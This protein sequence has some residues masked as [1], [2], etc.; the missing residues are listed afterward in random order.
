MTM[1]DDKDALAA[2]YVLGTL[3]PDERA[4]AHLLLELDAKFVTLVRNWERRLGELSA[5]VA[6][7]E[8]PDVTWAR[9]KARV[10]GV[11]PGPLLVLPTVPEPPPKP[12]PRVAPPVAPPSAATVPPLVASPPV[13]SASPADSAKVVPLR[14]RSNG[15]RTAALLSG[16]IAASLAA[17]MIMR[18][19]RPELLPGP[20]K[21]K[22]FVREVPAPAPAEYVAVLQKDEF[23][24]AFMLTVDIEKRTLSVRKIAAERQTGKSYEL[25]LISDK[26]PDPQSLGV[27]G[28]GDYTVRRGLPDVDALAV[29]RAT[30]AIT[31]EPEGGSK[32][33]KPTGPVLFKARLLQTTPPAF[34]SQTP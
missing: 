23:S 16:A 22:M 2:E 17:L 24:P 9:V 32:T 10:E 11:D 20:L 7:V 27:V 13:A 25:W 19:T 26:F 12:A 18:D 14:P 4:E 33:G 6:P 1:E 34:P 30:Y 8:P 21:P 29:E 28:D 5:M 31:L 3:T 15:W